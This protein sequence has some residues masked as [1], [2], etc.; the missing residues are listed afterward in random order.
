MLENIAKQ[1]FR[2]K[3]FTSDFHRKRTIYILFREFRSS[4]SS[5]STWSLTLPVMSS[6]A[7][8]YNVCIVPLYCLI[9]PVQERKK[10]TSSDEQKKDGNKISKRHSKRQKK[11][12]RSKKASKKASK[13][14]VTSTTGKTAT[15]PATPVEAAKAAKPAPALVA[16]ANAAP[17]AP[18]TAPVEA[19]G[20]V[21][22]QAPNETQ[23]KVVPNSGDLQENKG[24]IQ[25][26]QIAEPVDQTPAQD[27]GMT[28]AA[29]QA[30]TP[31]QDAGGAKPALDGT[32]RMDVQGGQEAAEVQ[33]KETVSN[34]S[35]KDKN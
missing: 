7:I 9:P 6:I 18:P 21:A 29:E 5:Y 20:N 35:R 10:N 30:S 32:Q 33:S 11:S 17:A 28:G 4:P 13:A 8:A 22:A 12:N 26:A 15:D 19:Q 2:R 3:I 27:A 34:E 16:Q 25:D 24:P 14:S 23:E 31:T 1:I